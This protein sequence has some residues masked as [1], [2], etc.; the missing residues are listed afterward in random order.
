MLAIM[1][2]LLAPAFAETDDMARLEALIEELRA[3]VEALR[4]ELRAQSDPTVI[5]KFDGGEIHFTDVY[6]EYEDIRD[7]YDLFYQSSLEENPT[8]ALELQMQIA[9]ELAEKAVIDAH[10]EQ[11]G[12][13]L[14]SDEQLSEID[15]RAERTHGELSA[16][17]DEELLKEIGCDVESLK[18]EY[19]EE[20]LSLARIKYVAGEVNVTDEYLSDMYEEYALADEKYFTENPDEFSFE[21]TYAGSLITWYPEG[22]RR[23]RKLLVPF[24][25]EQLEERDEIIFALGSAE[26]DDERERL[27]AELDG[28]YARLTDAANAVRERV[29]AGEKIVDLLNEYTQT[30][31]F[32][33]ADPK[34][35]VVVTEGYAYIDQNVVLAA[36]ALENIGDVSAPV[37]VDAGYVII[38]Y[39]SDVTPGRVPFEEV[40]DEL[41]DIAYET[42]EYAQ[43]AQNAAALMEAANVEY[44]FAG[45]N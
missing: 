19:T 11:A 12:V 2:S 18:R 15:A 29:A 3:E 45:L 1:I 27:N 35:G 8:E 22:Y 36:M 44:F 32:L 24:T 14:L 9:R 40:K 31:D 34:Q 10:L 26:T 7:M 41:Y 13:S 39:V 23:I 17:Y 37:R 20:A 38:E 43:Y 5:A 28:V 30:D 16:D 33:T 21:L 4:Q 6:S 25:D 42:L